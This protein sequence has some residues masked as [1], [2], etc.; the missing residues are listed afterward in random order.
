MDKEGGSSCAGSQLV[1]LIVVGPFDVPPALDLV[2]ERN[3]SRSHIQDPFSWV[4]RNKN[5]GRSKITG[6]G[7]LDIQSIC[8]E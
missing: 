5:S 1:Y 3:L 8:L 6:G 4:Q 7:A 2:G